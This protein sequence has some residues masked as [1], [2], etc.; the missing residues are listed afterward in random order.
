MKGIAAP[1]PQP[2]SGRT[3]SHRELGEE[4]RFLTLKCSQLVLSQSTFC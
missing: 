3:R 1:R 4:Q 2:V